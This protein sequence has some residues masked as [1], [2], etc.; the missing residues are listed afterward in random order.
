MTVILCRNE[1]F[2]DLLENRQFCVHL[3]KIVFFFFFTRFLFLN[4]VK[5]KYNLSKQSLDFF[6]HLYFCC[7]SYE[8]C[9]AQRED[10]IVRWISHLISQGVRVKAKKK[11][12]KLKSKIA[13]QKYNLIFP[14]IFA[15]E[16]NNMMI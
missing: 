12:K 3:F 9:K 10:R 16:S 11:K 7:C 1:T 2:C 13:K 15:S 6:S 4:M 5:T 14:F 8:L